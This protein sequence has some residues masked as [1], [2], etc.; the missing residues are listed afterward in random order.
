VHRG[1]AAFRRR[2]HQPTVAERARYLAP[3]RA[4]GFRAIGYFFEPD[5][6]GSVAR[7]AARP[8]QVP[9]SGLFGTLKRLERPT[10][11]E[12]FDELHVVRIV[13]GGFTVQAWE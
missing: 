3:A 12:G 6:K 13:A 7:N 10:L 11:A 9:P 2:Q 4:A 1:G 8:R 5:P